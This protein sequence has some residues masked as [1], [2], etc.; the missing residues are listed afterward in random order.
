[1][2]AQ[3]GKETNTGQRRPL[4]YKKEDKKQRTWRHGGRSHN[5]HTST[6]QK[7]STTEG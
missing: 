1:M 5:D 4:K 7:Q 6:N 3:T 2:N